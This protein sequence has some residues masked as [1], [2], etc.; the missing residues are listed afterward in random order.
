MDSLNLESVIGDMCLVSV[1]AAA[2]V[3]MISTARRC[4][5]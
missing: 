3:Y 5:G 4:H 1:G 2:W